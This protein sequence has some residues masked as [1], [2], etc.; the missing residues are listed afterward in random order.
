MKK[1]KNSLEDLCLPD[2]CTVE[3]AFIAHKDIH[4]Y[5]NINAIVIKSDATYRTNNPF[6]V[7]Y[8][9]SFD[10]FLASHRVTMK[11]CNNKAV[12]KIDFVEVS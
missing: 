8:T 3:N 1:I 9:D 2:E 6:G 4:K 11:L 12:R 10:H 7:G 5:R